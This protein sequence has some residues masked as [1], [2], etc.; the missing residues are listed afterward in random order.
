MKIMINGVDSL[1]AYSINNRYGK[2]KLC[3]LLQISSFV[4]TKDITKCECNNK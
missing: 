4:A 1:R 3:C 2:R